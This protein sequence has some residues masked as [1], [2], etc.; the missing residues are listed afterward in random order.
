MHSE[1]QHIRSSELIS[2]YLSGN[3]SPSEIEELET[4]VMETPE[5]KE[6]FMAYK[7]TWML[8]GMK[9]EQETVD[10]E[11]LWKETSQQLL[12][13]AKVVKM[14]PKRNYSAWLGIAAAAIL[15]LIA[16]F[17]YF[18]QTNS[19]QNF[20]AQSKEEIKEVA[21]SDGSQITLNQS[22]SLT[23]TAADQA[24]ER[25]IELE[26]DAFFDVAR[27]TAHPFVVHTQ[28]I[29]VEVLGTSFYVDSRKDQDEIQ[30]IVESGT[31]A[32]RV[33]EEEKILTA[34]EKAIF[35]KTSQEL[36]K[37]ENQDKNYL[38]LKNGV[39]VFENTPMDE[40][41]FALSRQFRVDISFDEEALKTCLHDGTYPNMSLS[42]ILKVLEAS[43]MKI[44]RT[45][46]KIVLTGQC[47][48]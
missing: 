5:N 13:E 24:G 11:K 42:A 34:N 36:I 28:D 18:Q 16:S 10:I 12:G 48:E 45:G 14:E 44:E 1:D 9:K 6:Q 19:S 2:K 38:A 33:G 30:V 29:V 3:A 26:G 25:R 4:W 39:L 21:L 20:Y 41:A 27:D 22:S 7:K 8:S 31:V 37:Q 40:V 43:E 47:G 15:L 32:V 35:R 23:F 17:L 46:S